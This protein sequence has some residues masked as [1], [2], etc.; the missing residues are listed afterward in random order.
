MG[1]GTRGDSGIIRGSAWRDLSKLETGI[2]TRYRGEEIIS[3]IG[4]PFSV[5]TR[6]HRYEGSVASRNAELKK[7]IR[8]GIATGF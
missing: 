3:I 8:A 7:D 6:I 5:S 1:P 2:Q 4:I